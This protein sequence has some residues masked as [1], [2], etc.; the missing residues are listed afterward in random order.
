MKLCFPV[1]K[2]QGLDSQV[3]GHFG[4]AP[5]LLVIDTE[6]QELTELERYGDSEQLG[7]ARLGQLLAGQT[8]DAIVVSGLGQGAQAKLQAAG[9]K[10]YQANGATINE[11]LLRLA[12]Q[13]L[14]EFTPSQ[15][16]SHGHHGAHQ[17]GAGSGCGCH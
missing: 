5:L 10:I 17:H 6:T 1:E 9:V 15:S 11:N 4:S 12:G 3:C 13:Q 8:I 16:C 2:N 7:R 14:Q